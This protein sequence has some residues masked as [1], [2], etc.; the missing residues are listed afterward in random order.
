MTLSMAWRLAMSNFSRATRSGLVQPPS[1]K[2]SAK[3]MSPLLSAAAHT[4]QSFR[5][6]DAR[7]PVSPVTS[8]RPPKCAS[9]PSGSCTSSVPV[10][11]WPSM[12]N[13]A[14]AAAGAVCGKANDEGVVVSAEEVVMAVGSGVL[15][16]WQGVECVN[17]CVNA[18]VSA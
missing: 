12:A 1:M 8:L 4:R 5:R 18:C 2:V 17:A 7:G 15:E 10:C 11:S 14:R 3:P 16:F 6:S 9:D 13:T